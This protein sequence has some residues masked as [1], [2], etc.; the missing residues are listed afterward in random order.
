[1]PPV[2]L[3]TPTANTGVSRVVFS[4]EE[5]RLRWMSY[6]RIGAV[7]NHLRCSGGYHDASWWFIA[8]ERELLTST[9]KHCCGFLFCLFEAC[10]CPAA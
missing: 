7:V 4:V 9:F 1:M 6:L 8:S 5:L 2:V 10:R 3:F